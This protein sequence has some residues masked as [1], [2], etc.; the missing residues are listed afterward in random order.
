VG[1][2]SLS[3][4]ALTLPEVARHY[5]AVTA[6]TYNFFANSGPM[7]LK[8]HPSLAGYTG[9]PMH[10][11]RS[12]ILAEVDRTSALSVLSCVE[13]AVRSDYLRRV[14]DREKDDMSRALRAIYKLKEERARLD[15]DL[16][17]CWRDH[18]GISKALVRELIGA[19]NYRNWLAHGRYWTPR[20][21]RR[22]DF[23]TVY[24]IAHAFLTF[25][26]SKELS[27]GGS[28]ARR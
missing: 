11:V 1:R 10:E 22:Y 23:S 16:L 28:A 17:F 25:I 9:M 26:S 21:G 24:P 20:F 6:A 19:F 13:A 18:S 12:N 5:S 27:A 8:A 15:D 3:G 14:Y 7:A 2:V 4:Q